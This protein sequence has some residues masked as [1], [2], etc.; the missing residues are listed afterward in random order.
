MK[1]HTLEL[2]AEERKELE[3]ARDRDKRAY[4]RECA[5]ALLKIADGQSA[6]HVA[7]HALNHRRDPDTLYRWLSK[8]KN[9]GL[10]ALVHKPSGH[11]G[12]SPSR[13]RSVE[14]TDAPTT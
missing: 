13:G 4:M 14:G 8:Y 9:G 11:R 3:H 7:Q 12:F 6:N 5:A 1:Q 10:Q 2:S